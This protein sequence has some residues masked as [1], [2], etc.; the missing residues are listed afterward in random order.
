M[1]LWLP[2]LPKR[3]ARIPLRILTCLL[4]T[5]IPFVNRLGDHYLSHQRVVPAEQ[6]N[7]RLYL[8]LAASAQRPELPPQ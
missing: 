7:R 5:L 2:P 6:P 8:I 3:L 1:L 4:F